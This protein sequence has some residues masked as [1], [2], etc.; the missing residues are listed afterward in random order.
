MQSIHYALIDILYR[1]NSLEQNFFAPDSFKNFCSF[2]INS[3]GKVFSLFI[4]SIEREF[5]Y[6]MFYAKKELITSASSIKFLVHNFAYYISDLS[7][8]A[9]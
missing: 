5:Q 6:K 8:S 2:H 4:L 9:N 7:N 1:S 3:C